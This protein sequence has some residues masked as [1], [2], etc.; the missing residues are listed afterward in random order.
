VKLIRLRQ[1]QNRRGSVRGS[2]ENP[3][4]IVEGRRSPLLYMV[5]FITVVPVIGAAR[6][7]DGTFS[8]SSSAYA[9]LGFFILGTLAGW[10]SVLR[11][12]ALI[13]RNDGLEYR[14]ALRSTHYRWEDFSAFEFDSG[15]PGMVVGILAE[16]NAQ[17]R[18][19]G[20]SVALQGPYWEVNGEDFLA[21]LNAARAR[22]GGV[23]QNEAH[24]FGK[25]G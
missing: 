8:G 5:A 24:T 3:P 4:V 9:I 18:F 1:T 17:G 20:E 19:A 13:I 6:L 2:L 14:H 10:L 11:P 22:W 25:I 21:L 23:R 12:T 16:G 15:N 7:L